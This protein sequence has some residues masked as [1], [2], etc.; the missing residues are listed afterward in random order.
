M[1]NVNVSGSYSRR[2]WPE[3]SSFYAGLNQDCFCRFWQRQAE[4]YTTIFLSNIFWLW[5]KKAP[6]DL[7]RWIVFVKSSKL[8]CAMQRKLSSRH[9]LVLINTTG[10]RM[11]MS[12]F[13]ASIKITYTI[14]TQS[15]HSGKVTKIIC[16]FA[17]FS[18]FSPT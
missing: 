6:S 18:I 8:P 13:T 16:V 11:L 10:N 7:V 9:L 17:S 14:L 15:C 2:H 4:R 5:S 3:K 1:N 12:D